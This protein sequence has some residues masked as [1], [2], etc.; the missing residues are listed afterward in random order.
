MLGLWGCFIKTLLYSCGGKKNSEP[1]KPKWEKCIEG[2]LELVVEKKFGNCEKSVRKKV[3]EIRVWHRIA[4]FYTRM[5]INRNKLGTLLAQT[6]RHT[7][8]TYLPQQIMSQF[9][10][11]FCTN[12][13]TII[14]Q[15]L[16][17]WRTNIGTIIA[18]PP[19]YSA[20]VLHK[21]WHDYCTCTAHVLHSDVSMC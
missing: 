13:G 7:F 20:H 16:H 8:S 1:G 11:T 10:H 3:T 12:L 15:P 17:P 9:L 19:H 6:T 21:S 18:Q 4:L 14:A 5:R 2:V